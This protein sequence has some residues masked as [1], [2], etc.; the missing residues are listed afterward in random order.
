LSDMLACSDQ[1]RSHPIQQPLHHSVSY[2]RV[3]QR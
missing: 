1:G 3:A 2:N